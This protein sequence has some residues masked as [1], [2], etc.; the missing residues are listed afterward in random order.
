M[1]KREELIE[2]IIVTIIFAILI[3]VLFYV[4]S[5]SS[6]PKGHYEKCKTIQPDGSYY[7]WVED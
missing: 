1:K 6:Q 3:F 2:T 7:I 4:M 5:V